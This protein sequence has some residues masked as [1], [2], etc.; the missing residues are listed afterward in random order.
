MC[1]ER[2]RRTNCTAYFRCV[3]VCLSVWNEFGGLVVLLIFDVVHVYLCLCLRVSMRV[4]AGVGS[5][6][7]PYVRVCVYVCA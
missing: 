1:V 5:R 4:R 2:I 7:L 6:A 3:Y